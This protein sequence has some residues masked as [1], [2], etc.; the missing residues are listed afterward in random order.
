MNKGVE[1]WL[2]RLWQHD[3]RAIAK[4]ISRVEDNLDRQQIMQAVHARTGAHLVTGITGP[5]GAGKSSLVDALTKQYRQQGSQVGI[6]AVDPSSPISGGAI[7]G[8]RIR[9][10]THATDRNVFIRSMATRGSLGGVA[11]A[12]AD[13]LRIVEAGGF[14]TMLLETVGV[15]QSEIEIMRLAD[16]VILVL[17]PGTGDGIQ[18]I[19]AG[20]MEIAD[21][22]VVNKADLSGAERL[23]NEITMMLEM[24]IANRAS[25]STCSSDLESGNSAG[26]AWRPPVVSTNTFT[27]QGIAELLEQIVLHH[28]FLTA[29]GQLQVKRGEQL[30]REVWR[31]V[32]HKVRTIFDDIW[33]NL[34]EAQL[35]VH[36]FDPYKMA[37]GFW[38]RIIESEKNSRNDPH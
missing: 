35:D 2:E 36:L 3:R 12:T 1:E 38:T 6:V 27:N 17:N 18:A 34:G 8:D 28:N 33:T 11:A 31:H 4:L 32:E 7:L 14:T 15:G 5:P 13:V 22:Y 9:M 23:K 25:K 29:S 10:Q 24:N 30:Q 19:K 26:W 16:T 21:I 37:D 20:I